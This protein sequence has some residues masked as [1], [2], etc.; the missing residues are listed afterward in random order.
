MFEQT[1]TSSGLG[2]RRVGS[3][4]SPVRF[5][6]E[7]HSLPSQDF[8][9]VHLESKLDFHSITESAFFMMNMLLR[10]NIW[11]ATG[12]NNEVPVYEFASNTVRQ[13]SGHSSLFLLFFKNHELG[14]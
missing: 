4:R 9:S 1:I 13:N 2:K 8:S 11:P 3:V 5:L 12:S 14:L 10:F 7:P 6:E